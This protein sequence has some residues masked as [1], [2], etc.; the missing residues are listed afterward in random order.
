M[1]FNLAS[2]IYWRAITTKKQRQV[3]INNVCENAK[4]VIFD[5]TVGDLVYVGMTGIHQKIDYKK[6]GP[7]V[8]TAVFT[9]GTVRVQMVYY[10]KE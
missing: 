3:D 5:Y 2:V 1:I 8:T 4:Q 10:M 6:I 7:Y 9:N